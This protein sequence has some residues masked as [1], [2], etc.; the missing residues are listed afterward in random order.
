MFAAAVN[1]HAGLD[2]FHIAAGSA[3]AHSVADPD[4]EADHALAAEM[5]AECMVLLKNDDHI[6]PLHKGD[7]IAF[8]GE[9]AHKPRFQGG[10][11]SHINCFKITSTLEAAE[12]IPHIAYAKGFDI[13]SD[14]ADEA[15]MQEAVAL[16]K[17]SKVAVVFAGLPDAYETEG[18]DRTHMGLPE[19]QNELIARVVAANPN[20]VVVLH[21][22][23]PVEMPW[24]DDVKGVLEAYLGGQAVGIATVRLLFGE[25]N[26]CGKLPETFP[27]KLEDNPSYL[28]YGGEGDV[29]EYREGVFVG[30]RYYD[31]KKIE[32]LFPFGYGLSYTTFAYDNLRVDKEVI[33]DNE[34]VSVS[35]DVTNTGGIAGKEIVQLYVADKISTPIRPVKELK[36]YEKVCLA[37]GETKTV[38]FVLDKRSFAYWNIQIHD[39]HV[40]SGEFELIIARS[41]RDAV[42]T[43][44]ITVNST[45]R[46]PVY[47]DLDSIFMDI[48]AN[49]DIVAEAMPLVEAIMHAF[50]EQDDKAS[51]AAKEAISYEMMEAM[52][53]YMPLRA[54]LSFGNGKVSRRQ[55]DALL[56]KLNGE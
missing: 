18:Y 49:D 24:V 20:T 15:L 27:K 10:G 11:S 37:P 13:A 14:T 44:T 2:H 56:K 3:F 32:V 8:I 12:G 28:F 53:R 55:V 30:Y 21:N 46:L 23:S 5:A 51:D 33:D 29:V 9:F 36:G 54:T 6:L 47:Y 45:V 16:A 31:K 39:W 52:L 35:V 26:P 17:A 19:C 25:S 38:T 43:K 50:T 22:G 1:Q 34:S 4:R 48:L 41:S 42:L 40:E 7:S